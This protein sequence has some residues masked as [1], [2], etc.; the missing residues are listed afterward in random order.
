[1]RRLLALL[2]AGGVVVL[3][4]CQGLTGPVGPQGEQG[5]PAPTASTERDAILAF[6]REALAIEAGRDELMK[7]FV[8]A[9]TQLGIFAQRAIIERSFNLGVRPNAYKY[10]P[11]AGLEGMASLQ[12][13]LVLLASPRPLQPVKDALVSVYSS[14]IQLHQSQRESDKLYEQSKVSQPYLNSFPETFIWPEVTKDNIQ[15]WDQ[16]AKSGSDTVSGQDY[17][18]KLESRWVQVQKLRRDTYIRWSETLKQYGVDPQKYGFAGLSTSATSATPPGPTPLV[19]GPEIYHGYLQT[20]VETLGVKYQAVKYQE[21]IATIW[22]TLFRVQ[23]KVGAMPGNASG[24]ADWGA[25][26]QLKASSD[27]GNGLPSLAYEEARNVL[28]SL[29]DTPLEQ[30]EPLGYAY[31][32]EGANLEELQWLVEQTLRTT[33]GSLG[34]KYAADRLPAILTE[35]LNK[36]KVDPS[37][38]AGDFFDYLRQT[39]NLGL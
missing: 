7:Y 23:Q 17:Q 27:R 5:P 18:R 31:D 6:T 22:L 9:R 36:K 32:Y 38:T 19:D 8:T 14:E 26:L 20:Y 25:Y 16:L 15:Y 29:M 34:A 30:R 10:V 1:M 11:P 3:A 28:R 13:K 37:H 39:Y 2:L 4:S 24:V 12:S 21:S 35:W 33:F